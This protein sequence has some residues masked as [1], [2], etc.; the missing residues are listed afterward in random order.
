VEAL[1]DAEHVLPGAGEI[2][3]P[4]S[5]KRVVVPVGRSLFHVVAELREQLAGVRRGCARL[6]VNGHAER[7]RQHEAYHRS[8][9]AGPR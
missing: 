2:D 5:C 3:R 6:G 1:D 4:R 7:R 8:F 9:G